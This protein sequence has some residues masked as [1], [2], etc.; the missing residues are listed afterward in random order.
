MYRELGRAFQEFYKDKGLL[1]TAALAYYATL[2]FIPMVFLLLSIA[3]FFFEDSK[4]L[5]EFLFSK[6]SILPWAKKDLLTQVAK[7]R[8]QAANL[9]I[10]SI[11]FIIWTSGMFFSALQASLN[12]ILVPEKKTFNLMRLGLPWLTSPILGAVIIASMLAVH[13]WGYIPTNFIPGNISPGVWTW[14][15]YSGL[16]L[17]LYQMFARSRPKFLP[18]LAVSCAIGLLSQI[19]TKFIA[20]ILWSNPEYSMVYGTLSSVILFLLW[21]NYNM[22]LILIGAYFLK[23]WRKRGEE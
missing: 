1:K 18:S 15:V 20:V 4:W 23:H 10:L 5:Q 21:L 22:V 13:V 16:I 17:F 12:S 19:I 11:L 8:N 3:G 9:G 7:L 2:S 6:L 14:L